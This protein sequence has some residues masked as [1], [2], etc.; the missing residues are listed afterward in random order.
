MSRPPRVTVFIPVYNRA[1]FVGEA[2]A[3]MLGQSYQD[4]ELLLVDDG[5]TDESV[6]VIR[7]FRD[8]RIRLVENGKNLGLP[9]TRNLGLELAQGEYIALLDSD[10]VSLRDRLAVQVDFLDRHPSYAEVGAWSQAMDE[11]GR[12]LRRVK[13]Q[14]TAPEE[15]RAT[16]LFRCSIK[17]RSVMGRTAMMRDLGYRLG[18]PRCQDYDLH[19]RLAERHDIGNIPRVLVLG[20]MHP[21][22]WTGAT[23]DLGNT[24]KMRIMSELLAP[25]GIEPSEDEL[26]RHLMLSHESAEEYGLRL[27]SAF[28]DWSEAWLARLRQANSETGRYEPSAFDSVLG[29]VRLLLA[30]RG[31]KTMGWSAVSRFLTRPLPRGLLSSQSRAAG[32]LAL[33]WLGRRALVSEAPTARA[34]G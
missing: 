29:D 25:L 12:P 23:L 15:I 1:A 19:V 10:D 31:R 8:P 14:P 3:S 7:S 24:L 30:L 27:D 17:N 33:D 9:V 28:M 26:R 4:F 20:R 11:S 16:L 5:S 18:F 2:I 34:A 32:R 13:I 21:A 22:Q 6:D